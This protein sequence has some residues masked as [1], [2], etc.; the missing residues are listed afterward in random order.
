MFKVHHFIMS[1]SG[2]LIYATVSNKSF[3]FFENSKRETYSDSNR[4]RKR[5]GTNID[6]NEFP[7]TLN[8]KP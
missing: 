6:I 8:P 7:P 3:N 2:V 1:Y 4:K 5:I